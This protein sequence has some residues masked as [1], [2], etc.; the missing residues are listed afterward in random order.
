MILKKLGA[1]TA[2]G[3]AVT[4]VAAC[5]SVPGQGPNASTVV[6][7]ALSSGLDKLD[8]H[9]SS[10]GS[11]MDIMRQIY[12]TLLEIDPK[13]GDLKPS[14]ATS[15]E[16]V[17]PTTWR[18]ALR[19]DVQFTNGEKFNAEAV[20]YSI[21]RILNPATASTNASQLSSIK[22]VTVVDEFTVDVVTSYPDPSLVRR[23]QPVGGSGRVFIAPPKYFA[24]HD[25][26]Y[27]S[28]HPVGTG[29]FK[30]KEWKKG[31]SLTFERN[32]SYWGQKPDVTEAVVSFI[33]ENATRVNA[34]L[35]GQV[36][37]IG[38]VPIQDID[39]L[40]KTNGVH[41][42]ES[43]RGM[44][45]TLSLDMRKPPFDNLKVRQAFAH[46]INTREIVDKIL[47]GHG[48]VLGVP[49]APEVPQFDKSIQPYDY[50]PKLAKQLLAES[51]YTP[52][53]L[54]I[55]TKTSNGRF[56]ADAQIYEFVNKQ[57]NDVGFTVNPQAV[58]WG[59]LVA[60][61]AQG[62]GGPF[63]MTGWDFS[64][65]SPSKQKSFLHKTSPMKMAVLPQWDAVVD[66]AER[67]T[68]QDENLQLWQ[69]AQKIEHDEYAIGAIWRLNAVYGV[70]DR[71]Q[72]EP[73]F[74]EN[75][76]L[77]QIRVASQPASK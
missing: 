8:P 21:D 46:A 6:R 75:L 24:E 36:D 48:V 70:S 69:E 2:A 67:T 64:E 9:V 50:D 35:A 23:M 10:N 14:L 20:K 30:L 22:A 58:E 32:E 1:A 47:G 45:I 33:P 11:D 68:N 26:E 4:L 62:D 51:G 65:G 17:N 38:A 15:Y 28:N 56:N 41:I 72:W 57:L 18:F 76:I 49:M 44:V 55:N 63:L 31:Q 5:S 77:K 71:V 39:R 59:R 74:G 73:S 13:T 54:T 7:I 16:L 40:E 12:E 34:L 42:A 19:R 53:Q 61:L 37:L 25:K 60:Q 43:G 66:R 3:L 27:L 52:Q 29:P